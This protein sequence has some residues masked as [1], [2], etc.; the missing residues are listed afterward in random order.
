MVL[1]NTGFLVSGNTLTTVFTS[2]HLPVLM[3]IGYSGGMGETYSIHTPLVK[4]TEPVLRAMNI[5]YETISEETQIKPTLSAAQTQAHSSQLPVAVL[6][7]KSAL[8][9]DSG[10]F[11]QDA[12]SKSGTG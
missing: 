8:H 3:I 11:L 6:L 7:M 4:V 10:Y 2:H 5:P 9:G 1:M 12:P